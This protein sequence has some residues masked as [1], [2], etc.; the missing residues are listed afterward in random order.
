M[1]FKRVVFFVLLFGLT[2][3]HLHSGGRTGAPVLKFYPSPRINSLG[4][5]G[6]SLSGDYTA[7]SL[8][9]ALLGTLEGNPVSALFYNAFIDSFVGYLGGSIATGPGNLSFDVLGYFGGDITIDDTAGRYEGMHGEEFRTQKDLVYSLGYGTQIFQELYSGIKFRY[10]SSTLLETYSATS[11]SADGGILWETSFFDTGHRNIYN[12]IFSSGLRLGISFLN[13]GQ[14]ISYTEEAGL[15]PLPALIKGGTS[16]SL[17]FNKKHSSLVS[18]DLTYGLENGKL[19]GNAGIEYLL[20]EMFF[21]RTGYRI[22]Y[23]I[24]NFTWGVGIKYDRFRFDYGMG[25][26]RAMNNEHTLMVTAVF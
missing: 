7:A 11:L 25:M 4:G 5:S 20:Q 19:R 26:V 16:Y 17:R 10:Y 12:G 1:F 8:N 24:K 6:V 13:A 9:P 3:Q 2:C 15:D 21:L 14:G 22:N 18:L 23:E